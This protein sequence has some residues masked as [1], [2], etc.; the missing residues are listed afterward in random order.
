M[1][2]I[3]FSPGHNSNKPGVIVADLNEYQIAYDMTRALE[4]HFQS[5]KR[6]VFSYN[7]PLNNKIEA[8]NAKPDY[9]DLVIELHFNVAYQEKASGTET[10]YWSEKGKVFADIFQTRLLELGGVD[11]GVKKGV[12]WRLVNGKKVWYTLAFLRRTMPPAI[13]LEPLFL[14]NLMDAAKIR[15]EGFRQ[16]LV[17]KL[18]DA[19]IESCD[20]SPQ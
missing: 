11:R 18:H 19:L 1:T 12:Y 4:D 3:F 9:Y 10:W 20:Y 14:T 15:R 6:I 16:L 7:Q 17:G 2:R 5:D 13:I 8:I